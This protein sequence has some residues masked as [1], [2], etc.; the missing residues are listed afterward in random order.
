MNKAMMGRHPLGKGKVFRDLLC[1]ERT[2][3]SKLLSGSL[4]LSPCVVYCRLT[5]LLL[6]THTVQHLLLY[7]MAGMVIALSGKLSSNFVDLGLKCRVEGLNSLIEGKLHL[8][9]LFMLC[10]F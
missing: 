7:L 4:C 6:H 10:R 2:R 1:F 9:C 5:W 8:L 3:T